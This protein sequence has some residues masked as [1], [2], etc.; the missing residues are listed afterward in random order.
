MDKW[1]DTAFGNLINSYLSKTDG[2]SYE[3]VEQALR[4]HARKWGGCVS[5]RYSICH[6]S[7]SYGSTDNM[8]LV[9]DCQ[10][11]LSRS[12]FVKC[13]MYKPFPED[14]NE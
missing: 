13:P 5:C 11:G 12:N 9:R 14:K 10:V 3:E 4:A 8:W 1:V 7:V 6:P 2:L